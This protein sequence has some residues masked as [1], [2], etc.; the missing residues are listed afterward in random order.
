[1]DEWA[2][3]VKWLKPQMMEWKE[4][5]T[6][7]EATAESIR[8]R[9]EIIFWINSSADGVDVDSGCTAGSLSVCV[10]NS[11]TW[12]STTHIGKCSSPPAFVASSLLTGPGPATVFPF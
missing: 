10:S 9:D 7:R 1:M 12:S 4:K 2:C 11:D 5:K 6:I 8:P 3:P